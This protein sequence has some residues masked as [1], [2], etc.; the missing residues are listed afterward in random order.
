MSGA[1]RL[2]RKYAFMAWRR[3]ALVTEFHKVGATALPFTAHQPL[4]L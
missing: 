3:T 4:R 2:L 1:K